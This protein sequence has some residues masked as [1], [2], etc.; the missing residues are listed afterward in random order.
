MVLFSISGKG[1]VHII[2]FFSL[3]SILHVPSFAVNLLSISRLTRDSNCSLTFFSSYCVF[4]NLQTRMA[5]GNGR[6]FNGLYFLDILVSTQG[7]LFVAH[8]TSISP[9]AEDTI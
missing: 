2:T 9:F 8:H 6:E 4:Q 7:Q 3:S 5:T 1:L